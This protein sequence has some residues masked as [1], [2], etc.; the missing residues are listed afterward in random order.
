MYNNKV[1][2]VLPVYNAENFILDTLQSIIKQTY[3]DW[4]IIIIDDHSND[5]SVELINKFI[6]KN[7]NKKK[8]YFY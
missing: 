6:K 2:I 8:N 3:K 1:D 7:L 5:S 4:R